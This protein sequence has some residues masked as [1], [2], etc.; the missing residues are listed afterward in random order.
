MDGNHLIVPSLTPRGGKYWIKVVTKPTST[1]LNLREY[2][3]SFGPEIK[4]MI[5]IQYGPYTIENLKVGEVKQVKF[6][7]IDIKTVEKPLK[8]REKWKPERTD[9]PEVTVESEWL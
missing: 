4:R 7:P 5:C 3:E 1:I 2:I 6:H 8:K 9:K